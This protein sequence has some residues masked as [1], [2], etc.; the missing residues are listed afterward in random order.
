[1][2]LKNTELAVR[3][4]LSAAKMKKLVARLKDSHSPTDSISKVDRS[5]PEKEV[6]AFDLGAETDISLIKDG[7]ICYAEIRKMSDPN[8][9]EH[10]MRTIL[11]KMDIL[12]MKAIGKT[13]FLR[14]CEKLNA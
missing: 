5:N 13:E 4:K 10:D 7:P 9:A 8:L 2:E 12:G 14:L 1:M 6:H 3:A 11:F